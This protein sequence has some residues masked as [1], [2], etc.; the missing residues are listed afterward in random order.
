MHCQTR[1][2]AAMMNRKPNPVCAPPQAAAGVL[3]TCGATATL[4]FNEECVLFTRS[5]IHHLI[6]Y[7]KQC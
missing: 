1:P 3:A 5:C 4:V 2:P 6:L 7:P